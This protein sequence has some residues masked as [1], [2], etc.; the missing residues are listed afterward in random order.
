MTL[1]MPLGCGGDFFGPVRE[2]GGYSKSWILPLRELYRSL[3]VL[4]M[5]SLL[6]KVEMYLVLVSCIAHS[7]DA[8]HLLIFLGGL[9]LSYDL[10]DSVRRK[11]EGRLTMFGVGVPLPTQAESF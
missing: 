8:L 3:Q 7:G 6:S 11:R 4:S 10:Q 5:R 1:G 2:H 9:V